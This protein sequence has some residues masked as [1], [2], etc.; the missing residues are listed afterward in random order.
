MIDQK[1]QLLRGI[2]LTEL[3]ARLY[4]TLIRE[5]E[6]T[7]Y[8]LSQLLNKPV[9]NI[10]KALDSMARKGAILCESSEKTRRY[11]PLPIKDY[12]NQLESQFKQRRSRIEY[13]LESLEART[14]AVG[15]FQLKELEQVY[16]A[17][18]TIME[19]ANAILLVDAYPESLS[20]IADALASKA[21]T[22]T[23]IY[24]KC[25]TRVDIPGVHIISPNAGL[26]GKVNLEYEWF[27][28]VS[29][30]HEHLSSLIKPK[31][32]RVEQSVW[33]RSPFLNMVKYSGMAHDFVL[34]LMSENLQ[35]ATSIKQ[36]QEDVGT[37]TA[38]L[39]HNTYVKDT[40]AYLF[41]HA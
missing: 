12:L 14:G 40:L 36:L 24:L 33:V 21:A 34:N 29:D 2:G 23:D 1:V 38:R 4:I 13:E 11:S 26:Y 3:E 20:R 5:S 9:A 30:N 16:Q 10:Y 27:T 19:N 37:W 25:Y 41:D 35:G 22:G 32:G 17:A 6:A 15:I 18:H 28:L 39:M 31:A 7:G 8:R